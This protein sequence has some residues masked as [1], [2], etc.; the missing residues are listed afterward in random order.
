VRPAHPAAS[1]TLFEKHGEQIEEQ[2]QGFE[3]ALVF[4][5]F[6]HLAVGNQLVTKICNRTGQPSLPT[7][8]TGRSFGKAF[9]GL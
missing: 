5:L 2:I 6:G 9:S 7:I 3:T 1:E 4:E 8:T